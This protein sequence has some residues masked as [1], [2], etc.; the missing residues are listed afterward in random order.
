MKCL[1]ALWGSR[2]SDNSATQSFQLGVGDGDSDIGGIGQWSGSKTDAIVRELQWRQYPTSMALQPV[3]PA[4][5]NNNNNN[6]TNT[7]VTF[8]HCHSLVQTRFAD[9]V[10]FVLFCLLWSEDDF[11]F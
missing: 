4:T 9:Q 8:K 1:W 11:K 6:N 7:A 10:K 3:L 5:P 2:A